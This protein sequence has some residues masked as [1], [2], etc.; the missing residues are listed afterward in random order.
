[1][2]TSRCWKWSTRRPNPATKFLKILIAVDNF[3]NEVPEG[4]AHTLLDLGR[5]S[6]AGMTRAPTNLAGIP[7]DLTPAAFSRFRCSSVSKSAVIRQ[8]R[9]L[10]GNTPTPPWRAGGDDGIGMHFRCSKSRRSL[11]TLPGPASP[12][13]LL[14]PASLN[15]NFDFTRILPGLRS[16]GRAC[17]HLAAHAKI[18][19]GYDTFG[20]EKWAAAGF[21]PSQS[22]TF[23]TASCQRHRAP[24]W[25]RADVLN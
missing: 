2:A 21:Q 22:T 20:I 18:Y 13:L 1:M 9:S 25:Q 4:A 15:A 23:S 24:G 6:L 7:T 10:P 3:V 5:F 17:R 8:G 19:M 16:A 11:Q 14:R 12:A